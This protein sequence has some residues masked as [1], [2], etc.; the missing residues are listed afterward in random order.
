VRF[1]VI[2]GDVI[3][4][5]LGHNIVA[6]KTIWQFYSEEVMASIVVTEEIQKHGLHYV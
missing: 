5:Y 6:V 4:A 3:R 2:N 1:V